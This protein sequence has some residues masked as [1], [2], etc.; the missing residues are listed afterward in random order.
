MQF[1]LSTMMFPCWGGYTYAFYAICIFF[2]ATRQSEPGMSPSKGW[3]GGQQVMLAFDSSQPQAM[4][5]ECNQ[6]TTGGS[7]IAG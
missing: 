6:P 2:S 5:Q 3:M 1:R 4:G 7:Y